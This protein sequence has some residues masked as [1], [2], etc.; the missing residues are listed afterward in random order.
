MLEEHLKET[1]DNRE[2]VADKINELEVDAQATKTNYTQKFAETR[3]DIHINFT[4][5]NDVI[6]D[7]KVDIGKIITK[8]ESL[9]KE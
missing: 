2:K 4:K 5:L 7:L 9:N 8:L 1:A 6:G 3:E